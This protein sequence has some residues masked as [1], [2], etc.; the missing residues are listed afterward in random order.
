MPNDGPL[1]AMLRA[2][3]LARPETAVSV[4]RDV[5]MQRVGATGVRI[6]LAN[7]QLTGLRPIL[8]PEEHV[9]LDGSAAGDAFTTQRPVV[10]C[11]DAGETHVHLPMS[12]HGDRIG[13]IELTL[14]GPLD[15]RQHGQ[16][17]DLATLAGY[18]LAATGRHT[19][20]L[21]RAARARRLT[22]AAELQWQLLP[23]RGCRAPEYELAGHLE[24]AYAVHADSFD[25]SETADHLLVSI[26]D[27]RHH[28]RTT[29]LLTTLAVTAVRNARRTGLGI[30]D[31][32]AMADQAVYANHQGEHTVDMIIMSIDITTGRASAVKAGSPEGLLMRAGALQGLGLT[33]QVPLGMFEATEYVAQSFDLATGDRLLFVSDGVVGGLSARG[34]AHAHEHL[35]EI[36]GE[37]VHHRP[38]A[39]VRAVI[40]ELIQR[41]EGNE[42]DDD[43]TVL[44]LDWNGPGQPNP[45][46]FTDPAISV[47][48]P[49]AHLSAVPDPHDSASDPLA[50]E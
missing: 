12:V 21:H 23:A 30:A 33:D 15:E 26:T 11:D 22:L 38:A 25:W 45:V 24:P 28:A 16:L 13:I 31:Q 5:L 6:L 48:G 7:Y 1:E 35:R 49:Q 42:L 14:P 27:A 18:A 39:V 46:I 9:P 20:L 37:A 29:P 41:N 32:A 10:T 36:L 19:D 34:G 17:T 4:I 2:V 44:C 50:T 3:N 8:N 43:A 40:D 47:V